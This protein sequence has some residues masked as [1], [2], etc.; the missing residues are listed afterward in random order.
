MSLSMV[1]A[2]MHVQANFFTVVE[3]LQKIKINLVG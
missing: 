2:V 1:F 3:I